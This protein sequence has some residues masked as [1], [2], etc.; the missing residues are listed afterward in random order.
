MS[1]TSGIEPMS[2]EQ[3]GLL[4]KILLSTD[5]TVTDLIMLYTGEDIR[6][7]KV[8][9]ELAVGEAPAVLQCKGPVRVL[10]RQ[11]LLHGAQRNY[12]YADSQF[13]FER[14]SATLQRQLL[15]TDE[16]IG[17][18]WK[19]ERFEAFR[20]IIDKRVLHC[21]QIAPHFALPPDT[22]FVSRTYLIHHGG[23]PLGAITEQWPASS[24]SQA[25]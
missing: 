10:R 13:V 6:V 7:R 24:F 18:L 15:E 1:V 2:I 11:I 9:Q 22:W 5:G 14:F 21:P 19:R 16:P 25:P 20:E 12:L 4:Q 8:R 23:K 3:L 17:L